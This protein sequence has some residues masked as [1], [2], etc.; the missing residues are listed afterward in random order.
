MKKFILGL[1]LFIIAYTLFIPLTMI[2]IVFVLVTKVKA[3][4]FLK[5]IGG[6]FADEALSL[7]IYGNRSLRTMWNIILRKKNGYKFGVPGETISSALGKNQRD[8]TMTWV[9]CLL[10][11]ILHVI[12]RDHCKKSIKPEN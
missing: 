4:Q 8:K 10:C 3:Y 6:Y 7:D 1:L 5:T 11:F 2:N 12:D 9:G